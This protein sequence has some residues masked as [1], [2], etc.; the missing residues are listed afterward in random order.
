MKPSVVIAVGVV[1]MAGGGL[2]G[3]ATYPYIGELKQNYA[4]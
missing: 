3:Q 1:C 4:M 2:R